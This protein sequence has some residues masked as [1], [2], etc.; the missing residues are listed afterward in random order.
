[1][2]SLSDQECEQVEL[3]GPQIELL[4]VEPRS[5]RLNVDGEIPHAEMTLKH[6]FTEIAE[7]SSN[8]RQ[9]LCQPE[10]LG[11]VVVCSGVETKYDI[12][13][14][15]SGRE[16]HDGELWAPRPET[17]ADIDSVQ[18]GKAKVQKDQLRRRLLY[19]CSLAVC[20]PDNVVAGTFQRLGERPT[21]HGV[22][23]HQQNL[24]PTHRHEVTAS[25]QLLTRCE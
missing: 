7:L 14:V 4:I 17:S 6:R 3:F 22:V 20:Y 9:E 11:D 18:A 10:R 21:D 23:F 12:D 2:T 19:Q 5:S 13:L 25:E 1:M 15:T 24:W 16:H 8:S